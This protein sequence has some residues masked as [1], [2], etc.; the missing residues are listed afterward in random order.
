MVFVAKIVTYLLLL[1]YT[2]V[3]AVLFGLVLGVMWM[4]FC[5]V[6]KKNAVP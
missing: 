3:T 1:L 5:D 2:V 6:N 4:C